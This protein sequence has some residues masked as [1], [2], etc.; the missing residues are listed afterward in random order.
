MKPTQL[1][2]HCCTM[3]ATT[4]SSSTCHALQV[5]RVADGS[6]ACALHHRPRSADLPM[7][8]FSS[9]DALAFHMVTNTIHCYN[10]AIFD[11]GPDRR[12]HIKSV[13]AYG[14]APSPEPCVAV[15]VPEVK[16]SPAHVAL[17][18]AS[19]FTAS[20]NESTAPQAIAR[21]AF[22]RVGDLGG[23]VVW[24]GDLGGL[25]GWAVFGAESIDVCAAPLSS[26]SS[27]YTL[28]CIHT[29]LYSQATCAHPLNTMATRQMRLASCGTARLRPSSHSPCQTWTQPTNPT[30]ASRN[31][32]F[33]RLMAVTQR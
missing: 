12:L 16:G 29:R 26:C 6:L 28:V 20:S 13:A 4:T 24:V 19:A 2:Q 18:A 33:S 5:W 10:T 32:T 9:D 15:F 8:E 31:C 30:T 1:Q 25:C 14:V 7:F 17:Y 3:Q 27:M 23:W 22:F 21:K 11:G